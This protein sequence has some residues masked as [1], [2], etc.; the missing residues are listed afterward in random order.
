MVS[1]ASETIAAS[2]LLAK[3]LSKVSPT[4]IT[5]VS[6]TAVIH[7][8]GRPAT[9]NGTSSF[10]PFRHTTATGAAPR[11]AAITSSSWVAH[12]KRYCDEMRARFGLGA[13]SLVIEVASN[14]GYLLQHFAAA[15]VPVLGVE[16]AANVSAAAMPL[17]KRS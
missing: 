14:D 6:P 10:S 16:P 11:P 15:D 12:A 17:G 7:S 9:D 13:G 2:V 4:R 5:V 1:A 3:K 8:S